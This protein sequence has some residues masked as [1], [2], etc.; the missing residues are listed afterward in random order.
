MKDVTQAD[1]QAVI[2]KNPAQFDNDAVHAAIEKHRDNNGGNIDIDKLIDE[3]KVNQRHPIHQ[4]IDW[5]MES[6]ARK[7]WRQQVR[8]VIRLVSTVIPEFDRPVKAYHSFSAA[9]GEARSYNPVEVI[10]GNDDLLGR[11]LEQA[12]KDLQ[13]WEKR[14]QVLENFV[15][16]VRR[17]REAHTAKR[18]KE[19]DTRNKRRRSSKAAKPEHRAR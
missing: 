9:P 13:S 10:V 15:E 2:L 16:H 4:H 8:Q 3:A 11:M 18:L 14:Y 19:L 6:A 17:V 5:D 7:Y 1:A 12:D